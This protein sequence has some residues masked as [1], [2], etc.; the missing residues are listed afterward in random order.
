MATSLTFEQHGAGIGA[1][2]TVLRE[3]AAR[4][5]LDAEVPTCPGWTVRE[6][7]AHQGM[8][9]RWASDVVRGDTGLDTVRVEQEGLD[10]ADLLGWLDDG[11]KGLLAALAFAP[12]DLQVYFFLKDAP[13]P[14]VAWARRQNHETTLHAVDAMSA[15]LGRPPT[16]AETWIGPA[17]AIDGIDELLCG[18]VPRPNE[19]LHARPARTVVVRARDTGHAW[20]MELGESAVVTTAYPPQGPDQPPGID[21]STT[22]LSGTA[23]QLYL[24]LWNR[25]DEVVSEGPDVL[26]EWRRHM[27]VSWD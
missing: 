17:H 19:R 15:S 6:L 12:D 16:A 7:V 2:W 9:H 27:T 21:G 4:A 5:G 10:S 20:A 26:A 1:A 22:V 11:V 25:G 23:T 8:V 13:A 24:G 18:F 14:K 3:H